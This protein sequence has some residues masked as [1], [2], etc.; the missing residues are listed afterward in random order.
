MISG[1]DNH[2]TTA[3]LPTKIGTS[4]RAIYQGDFVNYSCACEFD[5]N[6]YVKLSCSVEA[7][8]K[9]LKTFLFRQE[10]VVN[11]SHLS[12][13]YMLPHMCLSNT[14]IT[15]IF[16]FVLYFK[17]DCQQLFEDRFKDYFFV[18]LCIIFYF[19]IM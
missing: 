16:H 10:Y 4:C 18:L 6:N 14:C 13:K 8:R 5:Q 11:S 7:F 12:Y 9:A 3:P 17:L 2:F 1:C 19:I 15:L